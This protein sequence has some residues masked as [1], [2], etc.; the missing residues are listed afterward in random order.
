MIGVNLYI[1]TYQNVC[2]YDATIDG[3]FTDDKC[4]VI[5]VPQCVDSTLQKRA[6][7]PF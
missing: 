1:G 3:P 2:Q 4:T 6:K 7:T 5:V